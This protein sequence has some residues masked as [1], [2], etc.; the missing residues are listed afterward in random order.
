V[1]KILSIVGARPQFIKA[2]MLSRA[3]AAAGA[4]EVLVHTGQHYDAAMSDVFFA[5]M[6][7]P[8]PKHHLGIGSASHAVQTGRMLEQLE[9]V[10]LTE[11]PDWVVVYG[12]TNS[13]LAGTL[14]AAKLHVLVAHVEAGLRSFNRAM[15]EE[16]NRLVADQLANVRFAPTAEAVE[17]LQREGFSPESIHQ[18]GDVMY[19]A[20]RHFGDRTLTEPLHARLGVEKPFALAT[21]HRAENTDDAARLQAIMTGLE[22]VHAE[23]PVIF[24]VHPRTR[25]ALE[26]NGLSPAVHLAEPVGYVEMLQLEKAASVVI[27]DSGGVQKEAFFQQT[28]CV[29]ARTETEWVE[30][31]EHG[32][33]RLADPHDA[34][35][36][37]A[38]V[39]AALAAEWP[40]DLPDLYGDGHAAEAMVNILL[41]SQTSN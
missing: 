17:H 38:A 36:I 18:V 14:A 27:T 34:A 15:P 19:D 23:L 5:E 4:N 21:I 8:E 32:L 22:A 7:L 41:N 37:P 39:E 10:I 31:V 12:D 13:T 40:A 25:K 20:V 2:A 24:P 16:I 35:S 29:T 6:D 1:K 11:Q 28:P 3:W 33:N 9:A 26:A 30:L